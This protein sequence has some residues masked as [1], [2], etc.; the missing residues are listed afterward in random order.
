MI[1]LLGEST[2]IMKM[3]NMLARILWPNIAMMYTFPYW[4]IWV[5]MHEL[6]DL[7]EN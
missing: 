1:H 3:H 4:F 2:T 6:L 5:H 7:I